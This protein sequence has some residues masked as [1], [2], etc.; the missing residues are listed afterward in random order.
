MRRL[1]IIIAA[2]A[3]TLASAALAGPVTPDEQKYC[4]HDYR[5]YCSEDGLGTNLLRD[6]MNRHGKDLAKECVQ[7]LVDAGEISQDEVDRRKKS[8]N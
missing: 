8:G 5:Q 6:C 7:A 4:A 3:G 2:L 1:F